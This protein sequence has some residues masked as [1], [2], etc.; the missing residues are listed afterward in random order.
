MTLVAE[1]TQA[2]TAPKDSDVVLSVQ[3][4]SKK[5]CR[6]FKSALFYGMQDISSEVLGLRGDKNDKLRKKEFWALQSVSF[7]L[8][9]GEALGLV[10]KNGSGKSTLLRV[11]AGLIKPDVGSVMVKGRVAPLI[12]LGAGFNPVLTGRENI[13]ANMSILGLTKEEID[14]RFD[15]VVAFAEIPDAIDSPV[16]SYSSGMQARLGFACAIHTDPDVLL[17]D[18]VLAVGDSRFRGKCFQKLHQLRESK[19]AFI[20]VSH[21]SHTILTVCDSSVYLLKGI[22][23]GYGRTPEIIN[24]YEKDLFTEDTN[25]SNGFIELDPNRKSTS[26]GLDIE[27]IFFRDH[28]GKIVNTPKT[29]KEITLCI[30]CKSERTFPKLGVTVVVKK[31]ADGGETILSMNCMQDGKLLSINSGRYEFQTRIEKLGLL[32][33]TYL[34][35]IYIKDDGL[36]YLDSFETFR[37]TVESD[38]F[39]NE[40]LYFQPRDWAV[41]PIE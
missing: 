29:G 4:A 40:S 21:S 26:N 30:K 8:R 20:L 36:Y 9:R 22:S 24:Q 25:I 13:Y 6:D 35:D 32:V 17:I 27:S 23:K 34:M 37:F 5:F 41:E 33:G 18:E 19:T 38:I 14:D 15:D 11:I 1:N 7:E 12:A 28:Q 10:G 31:L 3:G 39:S 16:R 2:M